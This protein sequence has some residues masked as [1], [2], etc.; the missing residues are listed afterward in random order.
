MHLTNWANMSYVDKS[1]EILC[2]RTA[3]SMKRRY[4]MGLGICHVSSGARAQLS[5]HDALDW[6][7]GRANPRTG[8]RAESI[9]EWIIRAIMK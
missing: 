3:E 2:V 4:E 7:R 5:Q 8:G 1:T 6:L 9:R